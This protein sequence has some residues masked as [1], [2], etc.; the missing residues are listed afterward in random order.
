M[1]NKLITELLF[2][3]GI[4]IGELIKINLEDLRGDGIKIRSE[5]GEA[6]R[7]M[8][9]PEEMMKGIKTY[10]EYYRNPRIQLHCLRQKK[11][12]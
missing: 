6:E 3:G 12:G 8:G 1:R 11:E 7:F 4:R 2:F 5:K 10:I 9:L